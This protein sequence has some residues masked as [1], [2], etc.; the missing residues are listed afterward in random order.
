M[1]KHGLTCCKAQFP[2]KSWAQRGEFRRHYSVF[3]SINCNPLSL[4]SFCGSGR[5]TL[6]SSHFHQLSS[7]YLLIPNLPLVTTLGSASK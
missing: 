4:N 7:Q 5:N 2:E 6:Q 1:I 3:Q